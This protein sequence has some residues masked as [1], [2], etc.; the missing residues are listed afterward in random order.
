MSTFKLNNLL[1]ANIRSLIPYTSARS[2]YSGDAAVYLDA[3]ENAVGAAAGMIYRRYPDPLQQALKAKIGKIK[4]VR[5]ERIFL[6]NGSDEP[7]D[8]LMRAVCRPGQDNILLFPPTYGMYG[9]AA[10]INDVA[11]KQV[12]LGADFQVDRAAAREAV[13]NHTRIVFFCTP[14]NPTGNL[15]RPEAIAD[16]LGYFNG[17]VVV[18]EAYMDFA[19]AGSWTEQLEHYPNL[20]VLQTFSKAWGMAG[21]R[22]GMAF[23]SGEIVDVLNN[24]K[25]PYNISAAAQHLAVEAL[26]RGEEVRRWTLLLRSERTRL[27]ELL[28]TFS[29]IEKVYPSDANF[30]LVRVTDA[31]TLY[32]YL[33]ENRIVV[34]N[35]SNQPLCAEC[36]RITVG[37][38]E[39]NDYL[40]Q[41]LKDYHP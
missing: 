27:A 13:D 6:G 8:L 39:E 29:F 7:I 30:L 22:L 33:L 18:D 24:I 35:R 34:R 9:V 32:R 17:L 31:G 14:N 21:L 23:A 12:M 26:Q 11:V 40:I 38:P 16:M 37:T 41:T 20:V 28:K 4:R 3:N 1:R 19:G 10:Q 2:E 5:P 15:L 36:L 25:A